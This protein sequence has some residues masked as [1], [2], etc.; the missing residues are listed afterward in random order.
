MPDGRRGDPSARRVIQI[1]AMSASLVPQMKRT[2]R[3]WPRTAKNRPDACSNSFIYRLHPK[4]WRVLGSYP[5]K[6]LRHWR[7]AVT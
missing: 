4:L 7:C 1:N 5:F 6:S 2:A 3:F